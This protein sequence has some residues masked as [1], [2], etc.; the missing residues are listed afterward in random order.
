MIEVGLLLFLTLFDS[1]YICL[2]VHLVSIAYNESLFS[3]FLILLHYEQH[4]QKYDFHTINRDSGKGY[5]LVMNNFRISV[6]IFSY[7]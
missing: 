1:L 3:C 5:G 2:S 7:N 4:K 6:M